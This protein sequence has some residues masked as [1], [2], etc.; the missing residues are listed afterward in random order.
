M[1]TLIFADTHLTEEFD[2]ILCDY[3]AKLAKSVDQVIINGDFWDCY[4]TSFD[5]FIN[6]SWSTL[7]PLLKHKSIY[8]YGNHD[9]AKS[10]DKRVNLFSKL[11]VDHFQLIAG[12]RTFV[13]EHGHRVAGEFNDVHPL[14]S[15][16]VTKHFSRFYPTVDSWHFRRDFL[17]KI[18]RGY[19]STRAKNLQHQL[20]RYAYSHRK[21]NVVRVFAHSHLPAHEEIDQGFICLGA[22][23][24]GKFRHLIIDEQSLKFV[25]S[26]YHSYTSKGD[27]ARNLA[28]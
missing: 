16:L 2:P 18:W 27:L 23:R 6:S 13:I 15:K 3:I 9:P 17:G 11:Q 4:L 21:K 10:M 14:I 1:R 26:N 22:S 25:V 8:L 12:K 28:H 7:F 20:R 19:T 5:K 24:F